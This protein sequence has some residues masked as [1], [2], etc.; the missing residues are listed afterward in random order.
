MRPAA[1]LA[2]EAEREGGRSSG[3]PPLLLLLAATAASLPVATGGGGGGAA[4]VASAYVASASVASASVASASVAAASACHV[5][6]AEHESEAAERR[7]R[8][9]VE[10][11][12]RPLVRACAV[13]EHLGKRAV[14]LTSDRN[15]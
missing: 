15:D 6:V 8:E 12:A 13:E 14:L 10:L 3:S 4:S 7:D 1:N 5:A 2:S 9:H 11:G